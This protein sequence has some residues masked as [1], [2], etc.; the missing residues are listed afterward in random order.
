MSLDLPPINTESPDPCQPVIEVTAP[1]IRQV[2]LPAGFN[3][4][5]TGVPAARHQAVSD[6]ADG[7]DSYEFEYPWIPE[8]A[9]GLLAEEV[10]LPDPEWDY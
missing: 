6:P 1:P 7:I 10:G 4:G 3:V 2:D 5:V 8:G 9:I